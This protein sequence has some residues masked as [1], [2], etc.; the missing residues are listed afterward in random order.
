MFD[1]ITAMKNNFHRDSLE[2]IKALHQC[3]SKMKAII[4]R[5]VM[6]FPSK[7]RYKILFSAANLILFWVDEKS[8]GLSTEEVTR[9][10][11]FVRGIQDNKEWYDPNNEGIFLNYHRQS[12]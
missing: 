5:A 9:L 6:N 7:A 2:I 1:L 4:L 12:F 11:A 10:M 3:P 8:T